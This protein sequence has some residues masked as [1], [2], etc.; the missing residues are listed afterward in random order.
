MTPTALNL[1]RISTTSRSATDGRI[2][3]PPH[4]SGPLLPEVVNRV[5]GRTVGGALD[6]EDLLGAFGLELLHER[7]VL[8][9]EQ[10]VVVGNGLLI[11]FGAFRM[12][13]ARC[14]SIVGP[15]SG[16]IWGPWFGGFWDPAGAGSCTAEGFIHRLLVGNAELARDVGD[17]V[18]VL[19]D[20]WGSMTS[21]PRLPGS[22]DGVVEGF[23]RGLGPAQDRPWSREEMMSVCSDPNPGGRGPGR[24]W[25]SGPDTAARDGE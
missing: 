11:T 8:A 10:L 1:E 20:H 9:A 13:C 25:S 21:G 6:E 2:G 7:R 18:A 4:R 15:W 12:A 23:L 14:K 17:E 16:K 22:H 5:P 19:T 24:R 3:A